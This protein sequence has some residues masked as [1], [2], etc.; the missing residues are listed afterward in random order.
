M[1]LEGKV[2]LVTGGAAGIG[3]AAARALAEAGCR[4]VIGDVDDEGGAATAAEVGGRFV[5]LDVT[6]PS[7][8][9]AAVDDIGGAEGRLDVA[10]LNAG[11]ATGV[12]DV[13]ALDDATYRRAVAVNLDGVVFGTRAAVPALGDGGAILATASLG[14][15]TPMPTDPLYSATKHAV[16]AFVRS[17]APT[18]LERGIRVNALCPGFTDTGIVTDEV[19]A[20][21]AATGLPLIPPA[22]VAAAA[23]TIL[24]GPGTGE[25]WFVQPGREPAPYAFRG[26]PGPGRTG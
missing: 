3:R 18:L 22:R 25:A 24:T 21:L 4:V 26:V 14:G 6:D 23:V 8:W 13:T 17:V 2:A 5:P 19:R 11:V 20:Q 16:V 12:A 1:E 15:L 10:L 7:A 9:S